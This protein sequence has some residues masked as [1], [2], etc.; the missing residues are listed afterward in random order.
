MQRS[1]AAGAGWTDAPGGAGSPAI[2]CLPTPAVRPRPS[3][4]HLPALPLSLQGVRFH[5]GQSF[6][7]VPPVSGPAAPA[8]P[9]AAARACRQP[10]QARCPPSSL[11]LSLSPRS[12]QGT[13]INSKGKEVP[14][15]VRLYSIASSR[16]GDAHDGR[17]CT[18]CV[19]RVVWT[20]A[21]R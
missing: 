18:L 6:G 8:P 20:G 7:V 9:R 2:S 13:K 3:T 21:L 16:Y 11:P 12:S 5:E 17:T 19:V 15:T 4:F 1:P 14:E 10:P